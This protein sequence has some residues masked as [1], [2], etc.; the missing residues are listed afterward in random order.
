[1][2]AR[3]SFA[4]RKLKDEIANLK[5]NQDEITSGFA[6]STGKSGSEVAGKQAKRTRLE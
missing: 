1:L 3:E 4:K 2:H 6:A 5:R